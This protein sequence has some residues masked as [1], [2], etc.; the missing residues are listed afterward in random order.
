[1]HDCAAAPTLFEINRWAPESTKETLAQPGVLDRGCQKSSGVW[2]NHEIELDEAMHR[3][4][5]SWAISTLHRVGYDQTIQMHNPVEESVMSV[6]SVAIQ[7]VR[8]N[9][10]P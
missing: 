6:I 8:G 7:E 2:N 10:V 5:S 1:M 4:Y 3:S 9:C